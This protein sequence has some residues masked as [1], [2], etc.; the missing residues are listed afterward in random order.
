MRG[1]TMGFHSNV[2]FTLCNSSWVVGGGTKKYDKEY[3]ISYKV[4]MPKR[5]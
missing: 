4:D 2:Q 3:F 5:I 1:N